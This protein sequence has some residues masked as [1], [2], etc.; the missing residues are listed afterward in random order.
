LNA[1]APTAGLDGALQAFLGWM[2]HDRRLSPN[3]VAGRR[4]DLES[5]IAWCAQ[6]RI[7]ELQ[8]IDLHAVRAY[9]ARLRRLGRD[10]RTIERHLSSLR[11]RFRYA[12]GEAQMSVNPALEVQAPKQGQRLPKTLAKDQL[13][14][15]LD[16]TGPTRRPTA[17]TAR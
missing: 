9:A 4:R 1:A 16:A 3:T 10:A 8:R 17:A 11:A 14:Q 15:S 7:A 5:F 13:N 6:S 2:T 12:V